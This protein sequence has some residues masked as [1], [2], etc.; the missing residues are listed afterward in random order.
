MSYDQEEQALDPFVNDGDGEEEVPEEN[1][2]VED[3]VDDDDDVPEAE[4]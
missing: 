1:D 4:I 2:F 3:D